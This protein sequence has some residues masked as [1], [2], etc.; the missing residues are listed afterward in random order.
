[1][2]GGVP[3]PAQPVD[4]RVQRRTGLRAVTEVRYRHRVPLGASCLGQYGRGA[5]AVPYSSSLPGVVLAGIDEGEVTHLTGRYEL[6]EP[7]GAHA[8]K[9]VVQGTMD[10][11]VGNM[12]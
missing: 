3:L 11:A 4:H 7:S 1:M 8:L 6:S 12:S 5:R 10:D 9:T 2:P